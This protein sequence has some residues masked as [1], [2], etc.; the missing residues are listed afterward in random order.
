MIF[1]FPCILATKYFQRAQVRW[2]LKEVPAESFQAYMG[3]LEN[4]MELMM[5]SLNGTAFMME[6]YIKNEADKLTEGLRQAL[7]IREAPKVSLWYPDAKWKTLFILDRYDRW[8]AT[9]NIIEVGFYGIAR[10][11]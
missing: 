11:N 5:R 8:Q 9:P 7:I 4:N 6:S 2:L 3:L 1:L 10:T